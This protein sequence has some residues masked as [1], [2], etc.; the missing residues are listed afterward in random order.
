M[1][2]GGVGGDFVAAGDLP[3]IQFVYDVGGESGKGTSEAD[4]DGSS[5][6]FFS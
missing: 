4:L 3:R 6:I 5:D 1:D 2:E